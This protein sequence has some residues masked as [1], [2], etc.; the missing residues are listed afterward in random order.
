MY[1]YNLPNPPNAKVTR[2]KFTGQKGLQEMLVALP[3]R[4]GHD[5]LQVCLQ[6]GPQRRSPSQLLGSGIQVN[7]ASRFNSLSSVGLQNPPWKDH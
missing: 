7:F 3:S 6:L 2:D 4:Q 5:A 1:T